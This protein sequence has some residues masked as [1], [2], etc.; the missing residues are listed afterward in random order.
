MYAKNL[1]RK[2]KLAKKSSAL[3][4]LFFVKPLLGYIKVTNNK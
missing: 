2:V 1:S 3:D 4:Y